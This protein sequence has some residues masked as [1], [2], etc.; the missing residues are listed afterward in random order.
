MYAETCPQY[1]TLTDDRYEEPDRGGARYVMSP[2]LRAKDSLE[3][4][5][6]GL[7]DGDVQTIGTDHCPFL[8]SWR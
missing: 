1:L 6:L 4:L 2:P 7:R 3:A 8:R 5:W